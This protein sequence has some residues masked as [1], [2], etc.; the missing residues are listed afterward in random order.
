MCGGCGGQ[1]ATDWA[2][3]ALGTTR[4]R[5]AAAS[6]VHELCRRGGIGVAVASAPSGFTARWPT[7]R[8]AV[9]PTLT[10]LWS[11][12]AE[13]HR[14]PRAQPPA[15]GRGAP[16]NPVR[17]PT[18]T[19]ALTVRAGHSPWDGTLA[20]DHSPVVC[21][22]EPDLDRVLGQ[23]TAEPLRHRVRVTTITG[24]DWPELLAPPPTADDQLPALL[25]WATALQVGGHT[26]RRRLTVR[27]G[28]TTFSVVHGH[29]LGLATTGAAG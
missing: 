5:T 4:S 9:T 10:G 18:A 23:L 1:R 2:S 22:D 7:G 28:T 12:I 25:A 11:A 19:V 26:H 21:A 20:G 17:T 16:P 13:H 8:S 3:P 29:G 24:V 6:A 15:P 27:C 14:L